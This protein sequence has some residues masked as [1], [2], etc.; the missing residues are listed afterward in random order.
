MVSRWK[1]DPEDFDK[2][3]D[4]FQAVFEERLAEEK[5]RA[6]QGSLR[7][8][9]NAAGQDAEDGPRTPRKDRSRTPYGSPAVSA[10]DDDELTLMYDLDTGYSR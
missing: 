5:S 6:N 9:Y 1:A 3:V 2:L 10:Y 7:F 4:A 8:R